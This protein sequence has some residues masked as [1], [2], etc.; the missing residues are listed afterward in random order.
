MT[1]ATTYKVTLGSAAVGERKDKRERHFQTRLST[2][3]RLQVVA[4]EPTT[5]IVNDVD[6]N[7]LQS[8]ESKGYIQIEEVQVAPQNQRAAR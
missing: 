3:K 8:L 2:G 6:A 5:V 4:S 1:V 7:T